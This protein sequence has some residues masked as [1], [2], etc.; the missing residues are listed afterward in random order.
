MALWVRFDDGE[1]EGFGTLE[2]AAIR[3]FSGDLFAGATATQV[4]LAVGAV[5][6]R[7]PVRPSKFIGLWNNSHAVAAAQGFPIP[8]YPLHFLKAPSSIIGPEEAFVA[9]RGYSGRVF[10]EGELGVV[11]G[12][13]C[14]GVSE[15]EAEAVIFGFTCVNDIT[16]VGLFGEFP[17]FEQWARAKGC[18]GFGP[19]GPAIATGLDWR[20]LRV[21]TLLNGRERQNYPVTDLILP[22]PRVVSL[23]SQE[24]TLEAGD[25]ITCGTSAGVLPMRPGAVVEVVIEGVGVLR[26]RYVA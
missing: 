19:V 16:A 2:G 14:S 3:V 1:A 11:I 4:E 6:L 23:L 8:E 10:F 7:A 15:A 18:D 5:R 22:P 24:M 26:N 25:V 13:R 9:P 12:R 21:R 20:G 17:G